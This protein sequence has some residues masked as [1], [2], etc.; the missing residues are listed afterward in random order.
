[1][2]GPEELVFVGEGRNTFG[3]SDGGTARNR[4]DTES[5]SHAEGVIDLIVGDV[6]AEVVAKD[7]EVDS[8]VVELLTDGLPG[9]GGCGGTPFFEIFARL[10]G[11]SLLFGGD[12]TA[13]AAAADCG[14][15][16]SASESFAVVRHKLD[17]AEAD[18]VHDGDEVGCGDT[19][20]E[21]VGDDSDLDAVEKGLQRRGG[22]AAATA[23]EATLAAR[24]GKCLGG[25]RECTFFEQCGEG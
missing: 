15:G 14:R 24:S 1:V 10:L 13:S 8:G 21:G 3:D 22:R 18:F 16:G 23:A 5:L 17:F 20:A 25:L 7:A 6:A 19:L 12:L 9:V 11:G 2:T 4:A